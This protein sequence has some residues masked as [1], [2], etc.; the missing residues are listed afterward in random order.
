ML[1]F[2]VADVPAGWGSV[3]GVQHRYHLDVDVPGAL[4]LNDPCDNDTCRLHIDASDIIEFIDNIDGTPDDDWARAY[5]QWRAQH[6][7]SA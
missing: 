6:V 4:D 3:L 2:G 7:A 1:A 5:N